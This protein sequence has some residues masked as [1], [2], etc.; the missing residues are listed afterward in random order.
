MKPLALVV[1]AVS[2]A[3]GAIG[4]AELLT[5][6]VPN[7]FEMVSEPATDL[8]FEEYAELSPAATAHVAPASTDALVMRAAVD[9][10]TLG[11]NDILL[12]EVTMWP[13]EEAASEFMQRAVVVGIENELDPSEAPFQG[14]VAFIGADQGLWTRTLAWRQGP[15]AMM[16]SHFAVD[17]GNDALI[18]RTSR[19]LADSVSERTGNEV[20]QN[21]MPGEP[22]EIASDSGGIQIGTFLVWFL[23]VAGGI[24]L[25]LRIKRRRSTSAARSD[26][27]GDGDAWRDAGDGED[28]DDIIERA[29]ARGRAERQIDAIPDPTRGW[30]PPDS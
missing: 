19:S 8:T 13:T 22:A 1:L 3:A 16:V 29:R 6:D 21:G 12:R 23:V 14:G 5:P 30:T 26:Q 28:L 15:Y 9:V 25:F 27:N 2:A 11:E 10:W 18:S 17:E 24:W 4:P 20:D 7:G